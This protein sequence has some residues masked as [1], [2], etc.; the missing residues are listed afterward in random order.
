MVLS[1]GLTGKDSL[2]STLSVEWLPFL[3]GLQAKKPPSCCLF[4]GGHPALSRVA[5]DMTLGFCNFIS[6][7]AAC[8]FCSVP[9]TFCW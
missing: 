3:K 6:Q 9:F 2:L 5:S 8:D 1:E 7:V 4:T